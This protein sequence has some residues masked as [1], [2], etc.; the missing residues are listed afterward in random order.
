MAVNIV[1]GE[2][3]NLATNMTPANK[4]DSLLLKG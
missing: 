1:N 2:E 3:T 4:E